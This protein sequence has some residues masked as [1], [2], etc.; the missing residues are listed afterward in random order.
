MPNSQGYVTAADFKLM[1]SNPTFEAQVTQALVYE[2]MR[3]GRMTAIYQQAADT[4][5]AIMNN[6]PGNLATVGSHQDGQ[7]VYGHIG[8]QNVALW[9]PEFGLAT[10]V[11]G[12]FTGIQSPATGL[13]HEIIHGLDPQQQANAAVAVPKYDDLSEYVAVTI[14]SVLSTWIGE[15]IRD[16]HGGTEVNVTDVTVHSITT[17][18]GAFQLVRYDA[19]GQPHYGQ[20]IAMTGP[21]WTNLLHAFDP[22]PGATPVPANPANSGPITIT[23]HDSGGGGGDGGAASPGWGGNTGS[24]GGATGDGWG[25]WGQAGDGPYPGGDDWDGAG[26]E[27]RRNGKLTEDDDH[28]SMSHSP[29]SHAGEAALQQWMANGGNSHSPGQQAVI[30]ASTI[31]ITGDPTPTVEH[32]KP[33]VDYAPTDHHV[34]IVGVA[35]LEHAIA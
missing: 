33:V 31:V 11:N 29:A 25:G 27:P 34:E 21:N 20:Q 24:G 1:N 4:G 14:E 9:N 32:A 3:D 5:L 12:Q 13:T 30:A 2:Q 8:S 16:N 10:K 18:D 28:Q 6:P 7:T 22:L 17:E 35:P 15:P 23:G 26:D 19:N